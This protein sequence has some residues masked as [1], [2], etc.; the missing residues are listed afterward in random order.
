MNWLHKNYKRKWKFATGTRKLTSTRIVNKKYSS[1]RPTWVLAA[2]LAASDWWR[3]SVVTT[4]VFGRRTF[5]DLDQINGWQVTTLWLNWPLW[6]SQLGQ[7]IQPSIPVVSANKRVVIHVFTW[8]TDV[9]T[10]KLAADYMQ[11][12]RLYGYGPK[13]VTAG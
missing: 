10:I 7:C 12:V 4:S 9:E 1:G 13:S 3:R 5:P 2:A 6:V 8:I 11:N